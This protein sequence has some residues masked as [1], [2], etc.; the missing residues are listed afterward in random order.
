MEEDVSKDKNQ[1]K[2]SYSQTIG[3]GIFYIYVS[4]RLFDKSTG[5]VC[6]RMYVHRETEVWVVKCRIFR[7]ETNSLSF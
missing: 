6:T 5:P 1:A 2:L 3:R 4:P 7:L